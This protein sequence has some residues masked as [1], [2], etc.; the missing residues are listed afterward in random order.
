MALTATEF[1][2]LEEDEGVVFGTLQVTGGSDVLGRDSF[3][4]QMREDDGSLVL[5]HGD[6]LGVSATLD[7]EE[8][9]FAQNLPSGNYK[10]YRLVQSGFSDM[11][12]PLHLPFQVR[13][14]ETTYLGKMMFVF[15]Q[16][17]VDESHFLWGVEN[18]LANAIEMAKNDLGLVFE[19]VTSDVLVEISISE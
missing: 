11:E 8:V 2:N 15:P 19:N 17:Q 1:G 9:V 5:T 6:S 14:G 4:L 12:I 10:F 3:T 18:E 16:G 7:G 13:A